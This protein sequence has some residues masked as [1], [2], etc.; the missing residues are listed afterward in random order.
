MLGAGMTQ[1]GHELR[2]VEETLTVAGQEQLAWIDRRLRA[3]EVMA[4]ISP[5]LGLLGTVTGMIQAFRQVSAV[6]GVV[7]PA[8][9]ASGI[10][11]A[12]LTTAAGL[13]VAI[14]LMIFLRYF[15]RRREKIGMELER[16]ASLFVHLLEDLARAA[17]APPGPGR[18]V[19]P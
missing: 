3:L 16:Y 8:L 12:L 7:S 18:Q 9:L 14:P 15:E 17:E 19:A 1:M 11:E 2:R 4:T 13:T 6:E 10:W 5:L